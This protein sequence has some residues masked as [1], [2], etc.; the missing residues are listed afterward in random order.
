VTRSAV[1]NQQPAFKYP[2]PVPLQPRPPALFKDGND[3]EFVYGS[4]GR[5]EPNECYLLHIDLVNPM[6]NPGNR[7]D[8]FLDVANCGD[9]GPANAERSFVLYRGRFVSSP[10]YGTILALALAPSPDVQKMKMTWSLRVVRNNGRAA[11]GVHYSTVTL[12]PNSQLIEFDF[13]P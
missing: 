11:D 2:A 6:V 12:S 9:Q 3:I 8:E 4:V 1:R 5:L 10:N 7:G 13:E